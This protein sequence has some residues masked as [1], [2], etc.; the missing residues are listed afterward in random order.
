MLG[1]RRIIGQNCVPYSC[2]VYARTSIDLL[3]KVV[4]RKEL[5][6]HGHTSRFLGEPRFYVTR[7]H[8]PF[9]RGYRALCDTVAHPVFQGVP[10]QVEEKEEG[11]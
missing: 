9:S 5:R 10:R 6:W 7:S 8:I 11:A 2:V 1:S 4:S 3:P